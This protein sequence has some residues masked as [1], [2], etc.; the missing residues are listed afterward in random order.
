MAATIR[1]TDGLVSRLLQQQTRAPVATQSTESKPQPTDQ[2]NISHQ[3][4]QHSSDHEIKQNPVNLYG[5]KQEKLESQLIRLHQ[6][7]TESED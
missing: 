2:V 3:A 7:H 1:P 6:Q 4:R 5:Y